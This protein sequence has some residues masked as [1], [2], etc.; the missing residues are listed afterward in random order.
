MPGLYFHLCVG[1]AEAMKSELLK[2]KQKGAIIELNF[3]NAYNGMVCS[4]RLGYNQAISYNG[5]HYGV[6][7]KDFVYCNIY[8]EGLPKVQWINSFSDAWGSEPR[9]IEIPF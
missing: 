2:N 4:E 8:P 6:L 9:V 1:A 7:Y 3:P 5:K